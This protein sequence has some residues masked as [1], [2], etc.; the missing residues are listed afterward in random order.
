MDLKKR[1]SLQLFLM[2]F[3][4]LCIMGFLSYGLA[5][6]VIRS[7]MLYE[8][9]TIGRLK[10]REVEQY[11][12]LTR[13][14]LTA[15]S[16][17]RSTIEAMH[18]FSEGMES[19]LDERGLT[20]A[21]F[22]KMRSSLGTFYRDEFGRKFQEEVK[23]PA[24]S[25][26]V[27]VS[28]PL[29]QIALQSSYI[30][31]NKNPL[32]EKHLL[33]MGLE[34]T[35]YDKVHAKYHPEFRTR[36]EE[37]G[38]YDIF[39][40]DSKTGAIAYSV[41]K[42]ID[43]GGSLLQ[44]YLAQSNL[45]EVFQEANTRL[46]P[47]EF[48]IVDYK[49]YFPSYDVPASFIASPIFEGDTRLGVL[50]IQLPIDRVTAIMGSRVG[51]GE[52]GEA[53]LVGP[54]G[55]LRSDTAK[56]PDVYNVLRAYRESDAPRVEMP[57]IKEA[58]AGKT[59]DV[60]TKNYLGQDVLATYAP[61]DILGKR[62]AA[63]VE[64]DADE[65]FRAARSLAIWLLGIAGG[66]VLFNI[67]FGIAVGRSIANPLLKT[68]QELD[69]NAAQVGAAS[70]N[71]S[72]SSSELSALAEQQSSAIE[73]TAASI[74]EISA[75]VRNNVAQAEKSSSLSAEV[76]TVADNGN[77]VM[78]QLL[79]SMAELTQSNNR[80][81]ELV[82]VI[83][84]IGEK[85]EVIDEIV[86]QTKLLSFNASVEAERA[87]EHGR[88]FAVV[89]QEVGNLAQM[90][91][92]A[93]LEIAAMVKNS[94]KKAE[95]ITGQ[96]R[97]LVNR[98]NDLCTAVAGRLKEIG[99]DAEQLLKQAEQIV[100]ASREQADG[101]QMINQAM[102]QLDRATQQNSATAEET[103][104]AGEQLAAQAENLKASVSHLYRMVTGSAEAASGDGKAVDRSQRMRSSQQ[105]MVGAR[106]T[107]VA[108]GD[109]VVRLPVVRN[110]GGAHRAERAAA[111]GGAGEEGLEGLKARSVGSK[112]SGSSGAAAV[113]SDT[114]DERSDDGWEKI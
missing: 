44:G 103:A 95:T 31:D 7:Q 16:S 94:T 53:F 13:R 56:Q 82:Q 47:G 14:Q 92:K 75:M 91:G 3:V 58:L 85:T 27:M 114:Q 109:N 88:G 78:D 108:Q 96:N 1:L 71:L 52:T 35:T 101:I 33:D 74:E 81:Q 99:R 98:G 72:R 77:E 2:G 6:S 97:E 83:S 26:A 62:W 36:L 18:G 90:S 43:F 41:Y 24:N 49:S 106:R 19:Y 32:G 38:Y 4:P 64:I 60:V 11:F 40:I 54:D 73:E 69:E 45:A 39:L 10:S 80:I 8:M 46:G 48:A 104:S 50:A 15:L 42:E 111:G 89:A 57:E 23:R 29:T 79:G 107:S 70:E 30:V 55:L 110:K 113:Q 100:N 102:S 65:A 84:E 25:A 59:A 61:V 37:F 86:F 22:D 20:D 51:L 105:D 9:Q 76:K 28:L 66:T 112:W 34:G 68:A 21:D 63:V 5:W 17:S 67:L 12:D 93:A 87:G